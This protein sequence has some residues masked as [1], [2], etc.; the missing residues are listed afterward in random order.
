LTFIQEDKMAKFSVRGR[1]S[2][3]FAVFAIA[4]LAAFLVSPSA[5]AQGTQF[6]LTVLSSRVYAVTGGDALVQLR[7]PA[8]V[9]PN[10]AYVLLNGQDVTSSFRVVDATTL[11]GLVSGLRLGG[12]AIAAGQRSTG[13]ILAKILVTNH[14]ITGP[15][16]SG[17]Q[18]TPF[19]C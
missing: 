18:Q 14:P 15:V 9:S 17:P 19:I 5:N 3:T 10:D 16:F 11:R 12:N 8:S 6:E 4:L 13:Q 1:L 7:F 2:A